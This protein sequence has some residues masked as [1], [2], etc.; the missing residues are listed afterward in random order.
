M[1]YTLETT[2]VFDKW[3]SRLRDKATRHKLAARLERITHG[4]FGDHKQLAEHLFE[5]RFTSAGGLRVYYT[6]RSGRIVLLLNGGNKTSQ[7][8]DIAR[9]EKII[10]ELEL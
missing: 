7:S 1:R 2:P 5:L 6:P 3:L 4:N 8:K 9:A 10:T